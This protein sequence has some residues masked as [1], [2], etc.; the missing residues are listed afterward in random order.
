[1]ARAEASI[2]A[3]EKR[4]NKQLERLRRKK[5]SEK[6]LEEL[7]KLRKSIGAASHLWDFQAR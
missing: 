4:A 6:Q 7:R 3:N 5:E 1:M 2:K